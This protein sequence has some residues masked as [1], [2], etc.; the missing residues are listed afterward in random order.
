ML[1]FRKQLLETMKFPSVKDG[2]DFFMQEVPSHREMT[3]KE[4]RRV[5]QKLGFV[6]TIEERDAVFENLDLNNNGHCS[7]NEFHIAIEA[8]AP[9]RT[10]EDVR[11][12]WLASNFASMAQALAIMDE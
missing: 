11:R 8:A 5:L 6:S 10:M 12:R 4:W 1:E 2:F 7:M 3:K 9:V